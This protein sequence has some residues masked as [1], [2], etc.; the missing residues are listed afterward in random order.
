MLL[1]FVFT[2]ETVSYSDQVKDG[3]T[4]YHALES[5]S[6][7]FSRLFLK[8]YRMLK[9][10]YEFEHKCV[11]SYNDKNPLSQIRLFWYH[12]FILEKSR[13]SAL[14]VGPV[15]LTT[16]ICMLILKKTLSNVSQFRFITSQL[17]IDEKILNQ[18]SVAIVLDGVY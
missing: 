15:L 3:I 14:H 13:T 1:K 12:V 5:K 17:L 4:F 18:S 2:S 6:V 10:L 8:G 11:A 7:Y 16:Q 9:S